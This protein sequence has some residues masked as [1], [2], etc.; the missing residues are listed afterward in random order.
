MFAP[1]STTNGAFFTPRFFQ[2][3][4]CAPCQTAIKRLV[5]IL[6]QFARLVDLVLQRNLLHQVAQLM[7]AL[8]R[9]SVLA[10]RHLHRLRIAREVQV[11]NLHTPRAR[12][13]RT[14]RMDAD[15]QV[16]LRLIRNRRPRLK[17]NK[18]VVCARVHNLRAEPVMQQLAQPQCRT[19]RTTSFSS[20]PP[21]PSVPESC[22]PCPASIT[23]R[24]IFSPS[25][26]MSV[27]SPSEVG[28]GGCAG[29]P[30][31]CL[32]FELFAPAFAFAPSV[33]RS[34]I[35]CDVGRRVA[36]IFPG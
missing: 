34:A 30:V 1:I 2:P 35:G 17:R 10:A 23:I 16:R 28:G 4:R 13:L 21:A 14:V 12:I 5:H 20:M 19:S 29:S 32:L 25:A 8:R 6:S 24:P 9:H 3:R 7:H 26:R 15:K 31:T 27:A 36:S 18:R 33:A 11:V 22:P